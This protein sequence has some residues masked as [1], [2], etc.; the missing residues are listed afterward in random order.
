M[1][2]FQEFYDPAAKETILK[3]PMTITLTYLKGKKLDMDS[4]INKYFI[5]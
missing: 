2:G 3:M 5:S 1:V 4:V